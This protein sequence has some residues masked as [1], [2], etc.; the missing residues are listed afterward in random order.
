MQD[1]HLMFTYVTLLGRAV[2]RDT[3]R[4]RLGQKLDLAEKIFVNLER[5]ES[6]SQIHVIKTFHDKLKV[7]SF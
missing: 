6:K 7:A 4:T 3:K 2:N 5:N 1:H